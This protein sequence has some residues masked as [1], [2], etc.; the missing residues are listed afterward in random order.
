M[1]I[2]VTKICI[3]EDVLLPH[4]KIFS[5]T[6]NLLTFSLSFWCVYF[7]WFKRPVVL[8][9]NLKHYPII[10]RD[11]YVILPPEILSKGLFFSWLLLCMLLIIVITNFN[12]LDNTNSILLWNIFSSWFRKWWHF[13]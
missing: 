12:N 7:S 5:F 3:S 4:R 13:K 9:A 1:Q 11:Q 2:I 10:A 8:P 6:C